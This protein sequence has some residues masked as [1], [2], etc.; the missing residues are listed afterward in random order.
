[1]EKA[2]P[3]SVALPTLLYRILLNNGNVPHFYYFHK[4]WR[5]TSV[6]FNS[7]HTWPKRICFF[8]QTAYGQGEKVANPTVHLL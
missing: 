6:V 5:L 2:T 4:I 3:T 1:M 8:F 7:P